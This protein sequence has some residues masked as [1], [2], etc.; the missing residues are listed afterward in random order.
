MFTVISRVTEI[1]L[2]EKQ[3]CDSSAGVDN[4]AVTNSLFC[5]QAMSI[6]VTIAEIPNLCFH[7]IRMKANL[8]RT[9]WKD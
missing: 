3:G 9:T 6:T 1:A 5:V 4:G 7:F 2:V 8:R